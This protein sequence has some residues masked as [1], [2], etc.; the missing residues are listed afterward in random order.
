MALTS[1]KIVVGP[2]AIELTQKVRAEQAKGAVLVGKTF[3]RGGYLHQAVGMGTA[4]RMVVIGTP[5]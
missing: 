3:L 2:N 1:Y 4:F 5:A